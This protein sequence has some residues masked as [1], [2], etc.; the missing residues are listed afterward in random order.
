MQG[1]PDHP[2][3]Q[4]FICGRTT[5]FTERQNSRE[6]LTKPLLRRS[7]SAEF[8]EIAWA[9]V[10]DLV[11]EKMLQ[12]RR[13]SGSESILQYRCGGSLG[14]M[15]HVGDYFFEKF[16]PVT[17]KS[18]DVC[19]EAGAAAQLADFGELDS[20][21]FFDCHNSKTILLVGKKRLC[22]QHSPD[23]GAEEGSREW[24]KDC[25]HRPGAPPDDVHSR[26][27][28]PATTGIRCGDRDGD[29]PLAF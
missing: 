16:G 24:H 15:K 6:R 7:K 25:S 27:L 20:S 2:V 11:A 21:D 22:Q 14:I 5:R 4:G 23:S 28:R 12:Y 1:D 17:V 8:E 10:L 13:E 3:T 18:G 29:C 19:A 26:S 9:D